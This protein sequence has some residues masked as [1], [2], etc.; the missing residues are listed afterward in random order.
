MRFSLARRNL[1]IELVADWS[2]EL[3]EDG[4]SGLCE[5]VERTSLGRFNYRK[6]EVEATAGG[7]SKQEKVGFTNAFSGGERFGRYIHDVLGR[8]SANEQMKK[9]AVESV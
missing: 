6:V 8:R 5:S 2:E 1:S 9:G 3:A 7:N 4:W